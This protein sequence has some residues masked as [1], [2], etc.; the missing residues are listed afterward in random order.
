MEGCDAERAA[1][2]ACAGMSMGVGDEQ[3]LMISRPGPVNRWMDAMCHIAIP[4][5]TE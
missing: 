5:N 2:E 3:L 4:V 1:D